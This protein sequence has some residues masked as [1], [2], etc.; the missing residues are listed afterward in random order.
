MNK[1][2]LPLA[3]QM[4][5][6]THSFRPPKH[7]ELTPSFG[8]KLLERFRKELAYSVESA[9]DRLILALVEN[10]DQVV[11]GFRRLV[12]LLLPLVELITL[13]RKAIVLVQGFLVDVLVLFERL[14]CLVEL[15]QKLWRQGR[16]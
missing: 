9:I 7:N 15:V 6:K 2:K 4:W 1:R 12:Q 16:M 11:D 8:F 14:S 13:L 3:R 10:F 5:I